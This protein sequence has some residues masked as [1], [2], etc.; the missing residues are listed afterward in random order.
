MQVHLMD[1]PEVPTTIKIPKVIAWRSVKYTFSCLFLV[2]T[3]IP[4]NWAPHSHE[5]SKSNFSLQ[6]IVKQTSDENTV[7]HQLEDVLT[8]YHRNFFAKLTELYSNQLEKLLFLTCNTA[9]M[10]DPQSHTNDCEPELKHLDKNNYRWNLEQNKEMSRNPYL[11]ENLK[12][13]ASFLHANIRN[14]Q[15]WRES[16]SYL[17]QFFELYNLME[18]VVQDVLGIPNRRRQFAGHSQDIPTLT[19][20]VL[21]VIFSA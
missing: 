11:F 18:D 13:E 15:Q 12:F 1:H 17:I 16:D 8:M 7:I 9:K 20:V 19:N 5:W 2:P 21:K 14:W 4:R 3:K 10:K 6:Y